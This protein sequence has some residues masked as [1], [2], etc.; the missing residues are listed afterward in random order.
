MVSCT[1]LLSTCAF[2]IGDASVAGKVMTAASI[3]A[4][5][6]RST[7]MQGISSHNL[8]S[9]FTPIHCK[10]YPNLRTSEEE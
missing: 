7:I 9:Y 1:L 8:H 5:K 4:G 10:F 6:L 2:E 3:R